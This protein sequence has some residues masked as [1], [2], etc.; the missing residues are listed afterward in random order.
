MCTRVKTI[1]LA[2]L[3][4]A[5]AVS[6]VAGRVAGLTQASLP[7]WLEGAS[8]TAQ[9]LERGF[10]PQARQLEEALCQHQD[11]LLD[12]LQDPRSTDEQIRSQVSAVCDAREDL[13]RAVGGHV[14]EL[15]DSLPRPQGRCLMQCCSQLQHQE[16]QRRYRWR[17]GQSEVRP[18]GYPRGNG[19]GGQAGPGMGRGGRYRWGRQGGATQQGLEL[20]DGQI[21][22]AH[23][24]DPLFDE[25]A[26]RL[27]EQVADAHVALVRVFEAEEAPEGGLDSAIDALVAA[28]TAMEQRVS[29]HVLLLRPHLTTEQIRS[30]V[31]LCQRPQ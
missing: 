26:S 31:G 3:L 14:A 23:Q 21:T 4:G 6:F 30:L 7:D 9:G 15:H 12:L 16:L 19:R 1:L 25:D 10:M 22:L 27:R 17:G 5:G 2:A 29:E 24:L 20:T 11:A 8:D 28:H 18:Q 13:I